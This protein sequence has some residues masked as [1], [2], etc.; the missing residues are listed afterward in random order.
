M[1]VMASSV[2]GSIERRILISLI[3]N[4]SV[5]GRISSKWDGKL[6]RSSVSNR[7]G[8][9]CVDFYK[10]HGDSPGRAIDSLYDSWSEGQRDQRQAEEVGRFL[11]ELGGEYQQ[12]AEEY[13]NTEHLLDV[14]GKHF[15][16]VRQERLREEIDSAIQA[17]DQD[18]VDRL[19]ESY[20][21]VELGIGAGLHPLNDSEE[22]K[23]VF[24]DNHS[25]LIVEY[26]GA[27][28]EFFSFDMSRD[29]FVVFLGSA[30][31]GKSFWLQDIAWRALL[32]RKRVAYFEAGDLSKR[33]V[34]RRFLIRASNWPYFST[35]K[36]EPF[37]PCTVKIPVEMEVGLHTQTQKRR[38]MVTKYRE[39]EY[40]KQL[41][42]E[43]AWEACKKVMKKRVRSKE[44]YLKLSVHSNSS[45][46]IDEIRSALD[47]WAMDGWVSDVV[48][49]D[50]PDIMARPKA[51]KDERDGINMTW[52]QLRRLSQEYHNLVVA[53]TQADADSYTQE[54]LGKRNFSGDRR[55]HDHVS[56]MYGINR[57]DDEAA[58]GMCRLNVINRREGEA[59]T[60]RCVYV[61]QCLPLGKPA[62]LSSF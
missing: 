34:E 24:T 21:K 62:V 48:I 50:Y 12:L 2:D 20:R 28:G 51:A 44:A 58:E 27:L 8:G 10:K 23:S 13:A 37:W 16:E 41:N 56:A 49:V 7:I 57:T 19:I 15:R 1:V 42:Y 55:K 45:L 33:Q 26:D 14:A 53:A 38:G 30:K 46:S 4:K 59:V 54:T 31:S 11:Q 18:R 43:I 52:Q 25:E 40:E 32:N 36:K 61:A 22:V 5:L 6:F 9:L 60:K 29:Q 3:L 39:E 47:G 17:H 35:N